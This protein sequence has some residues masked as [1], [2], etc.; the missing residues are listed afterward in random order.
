MIRNNPT[1]LEM[2]IRHSKNIP[3]F[4][5]MK[6]GEI[7]ALVS[8]QKTQT[9]NKN[10]YVTAENS[11]NTFIHIIIYGSFDM[12]IQT[13]RIDRLKVGDMFGIGSVLRKEDGGISKTTVKGSA[14]KSLVLS[15]AINPVYA[16]PCMLSA[17]FYQNI[18]KY[19]ASKLS[20]GHKN[21]NV[22]N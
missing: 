17:R 13:K 8:G 15:F 6:P 10:Q 19:F 4:N 16:E 20:L 22:P 21:F 3:L 14:E 5:N 1:S 9:V 2:I 18:A 12:N 11:M 7:C